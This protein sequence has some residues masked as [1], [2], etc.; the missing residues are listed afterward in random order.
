MSDETASIA[1]CP[2]CVALPGD[3]AKSLGTSRSDVLR[4]IEL[5][6][7]TIHCAACISGVETGLE[8]LPEIHGA[9]V[10]LSRKRVSITVEDIPGIEEHLISLLT[11]W[12]YPARELDSAILEKET[13][14]RIARDLL[15]RVAV[16]GFAAMN[17]MLL[18]VS[19]WAGAEAATRDLMHWISAFIALPT[20]AFVGMPFF[21]N[22]WSALRVGRLNMDVPISLALVLAS[23]VSLAETIQGGDHAYFDAALSLSFFLL[24]GRYLDYRTRAVARSA[25]TE[26]AALEVHKAVRVLADGNRETVPMDAL[27]EGDLVAVAAGG[28]I[29]VDGTV[30]EGRSELDPS[31]L[32]GE[33]MPEPVE[34]G[35][36]AVAGMLNLTGPLVVRIERLGE[37]TL[38][39]QI[40]RLVEAA[41]TS[42]NKYT[43]L[44]EKAA[45]IYAPLVH[46]LAAA[47]FLFWGFYS[48]DWRLAVNIAAAVLIITCPCAL[49]LAVPAVL[50]AA[51]GR[52]FRN[53]VL[54]KEG[55]ALERLAEVDTVVFDKTGTLTTGTPR[56]VNGDAVSRDVLAVAAA[57]A[58]GSA[59]PLSNAVRRFALDHDL[60]LAT[61]DDVTEEPGMGTRAMLDG[62]EVRLGRAVWC[63]VDP[64]AADVGATA[65]WCRIGQGPATAFLFE[66]TVRPEAPEAVQA[67]KSAGLDVHLLSGD[68]EAPV[69]AMAQT[70]GIDH[71]RAAATPAE[72]VDA[73]RALADDGRKVLM[74]GDGL[75]DAA[76]LASAYVSMSPATAVDASRVT[77][78]LILVGNDLTEVGRS[79][80]LA[81]KAKR[82]IVENF[83]IAAVYNSI[84]VPVALLGFATPLIAALAM[85]GSSITVSL[86]AMRLGRKT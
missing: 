13:G 25:A 37:E 12:G 4:R 67:L 49:G 45:N 74:V 41:E 33:T 24:V 70:L 18:S 54:L 19:V 56:L 75:N 83:T 73:L 63:G 57:L 72:K 47:A 2:A 66:D 50:T 79:I 82:R 27:R 60:T 80:L 21:R 46:I 43:S 5:S 51:S 84:A 39:K 62:S 85:S 53:G 1:A 34:P 7:P 44:A 58:G 42:K 11:D 40:T 86:N 26:L 22:A 36:A 38:L 68:S 61:L 9:R 28:R 10:N 30:V 8:R 81:Q 69:R 23:G 71:W 15:A 65:T 3:K 35:G 64:Q 48:G 52:L 59:H 17:V 6:L 77:A 16:A 31:M 20:V 32:T 29:P 76:A 14:D 55:V 78:D